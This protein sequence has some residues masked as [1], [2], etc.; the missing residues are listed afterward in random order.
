MTTETPVPVW[1]QT[2][3]TAKINEIITNVN[4]E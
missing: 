1:T 3:H 2:I 4:E